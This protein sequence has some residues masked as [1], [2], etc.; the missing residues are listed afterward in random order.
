[1]TTQPKHTPTPWTVDRESDSTNHYIMGA[2][3]EDIAKV[4][5]EDMRGDEGN[6][7][8]AFIVRACNSHAALVEALGNAINTI[9]W[10]FNSP[11]SPHDSEIEGAVKKYKSTLALAKGE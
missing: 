3:D 4:F 6:N 11:S 1:M 7:N 8:S 2:N 9:E 10:M 5:L